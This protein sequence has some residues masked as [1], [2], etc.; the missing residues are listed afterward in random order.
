MLNL[1]ILGSGAAT[2]TLKRGVTS[3][4]LNFNERK[5]LI[6][7][8]EGTQLQ[9]RKFKI[10]FQRLQ[11]IFISHLHG[12]HYLGLMGLL[13]SMHLLGRTKPIYVF[14]PPELQEILETQFRLT[15]VKL[16]F[17]IIY[18][19]LK[20]KEKTLIFEDNIIE[21]F[22][23]P[24]KHRI[25]CYGFLFKEKPKERGMIKE[26]IDEL[27]IKIPEILKLKVS[28][29]VTREDKS[30]LSYLELTTPPDNPKSYAF[31]TDTK[32]IESLSETLKDVDLL[33]H[34]ATFIQGLLKRAKATYHTTAFQAA[35]LA[36][37]A[38][39]GQLLLGHFSQRYSSTKDI[40]QEAKSVFENTTCVKDGDNFV[41]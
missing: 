40:E 33:Y 8:G 11:F 17:D 2:P 35:S 24:L 27:D 14:A 37:D 26:K 7:C 18:H 38:H 3:Q 4:Y 16:K 5:I 20:F 9:L 22:A 41:L 1:T 19:P 28:E 39:V 31:C 6:D 32:Y 36:K 34:E 30:V 13:S 23:F 21:V 25:P 12:D 15:Y 29:N 10:S